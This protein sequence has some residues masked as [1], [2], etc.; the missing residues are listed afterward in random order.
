MPGALEEEGQLQTAPDFNLE[1][2]TSKGV[3]NS[4]LSMRP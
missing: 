3:F 1:G 4:F 2:S